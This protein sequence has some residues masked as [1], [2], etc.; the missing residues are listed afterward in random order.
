MN[1]TPSGIRDNHT[2]GSVADFLREHIQ[3]GAQLSFVSAYFTIYAY[4]MLRAQFNDIAHL[5]FLFGEP[6]FISKL[7]PE[8]RE[9]KAFGLV[10][11]TLSLTNVLSQ[12]AAARECA[13]W[14]QQKV[15]IRSIV[16]QNL[17]HGKMYYI[18]QGPVA[19]AIM[20]SS[21]FTV[22]GLG[23]TTDNNN[24]ELNMEV[25]SDRD[26][27]D[28]RNWFNH[29]W[30]NPKLVKDVKA[31]VLQYLNQI[32][33]NHSPEF[34]YY[35]TLYHIFEKYL[36]DTAG[37]I[38]DIGQ[39]SLYSSQIWQAL[40]DFQRDG[41]KGAIN[42]IQAYNG[43]I[44]A[45]SVGLGKTYEALAVIK[46]YE[47]KNERVLVICPRRLRENWTI[48]TQNTQMNPFIN[49]R[50]RFDVVSHTDIGREKGSTGDID[51]AT[52][53]WDNYDVIVID[54]SHN[55]RNN[56]VGTRDKNGELRKSRYR[57]L[58]DDILK[59]GVKTKVL[60]L[61]ATPVNN[62]LQDLRNQIHLM[63]EG[64][65]R[66]F[67]PNI[68]ISS[69]NQMMAE[70]QRIFARWAKQPDRQVTQ[71]L[72]QL[73]S[74]F[75]RVLDEITIARSR[76]HISKYYA[77]SAQQIAFPTR[78]PPISVSPHVDT[79]GM[80]P[81]Y[82]KISQEI[83]GYKLAIFSPSQYVL[84]QYRAQYQ[85]K[86][87]DPFSQGD[88]EHYLIGMMKVNFLK[89]L[90]SSVVSFGLT[91]SRTIDKIN[92]L[93]QMITAFM[94]QQSRALSADI[95]L[96]D[97][98]EDDELTEAMHQTVGKLQFPLAHLDVA[99]WLNDIRNDR[100]QLKILYN[101]ASQITPA[102][103]YKLNL[104][105][106]HINQK[107]NQPSTMH[108]GTPNRKVIIFTA[109]ADTAEYLY[110]ALREKL[111]KDGVHVAMVSGGGTSATTFG[112]NEFQAILTNFA[113][114]AKRRANQPSMPQTGEIDILIATDCI[115]E[116][117]N[118]Q[119]CD[120]LINYDI[121]WNPV[122]IIQRFGRIDRIGSPNA[123]IGMINFWPTDDLNAYINLR[124]RV[125][126]RMALVDLT[127]TGQD[128]VLQPQEIAQAIAEDIS[129]RDKQLQ[130]LINGTLDIDDDSNNVSLT[131]F[132]L[133]DFRRELLNYIDKHHAAITQAPK[134]LYAVVGTNPQVPHAQP[135]VVFCLQQK[136]TP[137]SGTT[138]NPIQPYFL[139]YIRNDGNLLYN[140]MQPKQA[141]EVMRLLS[142]GQH[143]PDEL[144][145][146]A[147]DQRTANGHDMRLYSGL[148]NRAIGHIRQAM[149][150]R[151]ATKVTNSR[152]FVIPT[153]TEQVHSEDDFELVTWMV[154]D[155]E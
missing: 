58:L 88:R 151:I 46:Y 17:M 98:R 85:H 95:E 8:A 114:R 23:L 47:L 148:L 69:M 1:Y 104:L 115:S 154:I 152:D 87:N 60:M 140:F 141:L 124:N 89:R 100:E 107:V 11:N 70:A 142:S 7:D 33:S 41:V 3:P 16:Q 117:Q 116:G 80:F 102:R 61:S 84:P 145:C 144:L 55:F 92:Q 131:S 155:H 96:I 25:D 123:H 22:R 63:T 135:G 42:K 76:A 14:I 127:A 90:E 149:H 138:L 48:Y 30:D 91:L 75:F 9:A 134:G 99:R 29:I 34:I 62:D 108:N 18:Q 126:S 24:Y 83:D 118:L 5:N 150:Q 66:A 78:R 97:D 27:A 110:Q 109:F 74:S 68:G 50:F 43:C 65:D 44:I 77:Q 38:K 129:Y 132:T 53:N 45:D 52:F 137:P 79:Q 121:H 106:Q 10:D 81:S 54:E 15:S 56:L 28:L 32:Y 122:R 59:K 120:L 113:P 21:N 6:S 139:A 73:P 71:L 51:F 146:Q 36:N 130:K 153:T 94:A 37:T 133:E 105:Y 136:Q 49:D 125:E 82:A 4:Y 86:Q 101:S 19:K 13:E 2:R 72:T 39:T 40:F 26:R 103:D 111:V 12:R 67:A 35:K 119:D 57:V 128:N 143:R 93:E 147:F 64:N 112:A 20:G 31:E